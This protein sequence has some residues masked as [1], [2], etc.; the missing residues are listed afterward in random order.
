MLRR[1]D[2]DR[3][4]GRLQKPSRSLKASFTRNKKIPTSVEERVSEDFRGLGVSSPNGPGLVYIPPIRLR[5]IY[6]GLEVSR[7]GLEPGT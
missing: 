2:G 7:P 1:Q 3:S 6:G 5:L 4:Y